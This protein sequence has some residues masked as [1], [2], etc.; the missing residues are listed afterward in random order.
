M[1]ILSSRKITQRTIWMR[2][3]VIAGLL[4]VLVGMALGYRPAVNRYMIWKQQRALAQA[5]EFIEQSDFPSAKL[6]LN[7]ALTAVPG[8]SQALRVAADLLEQAGSPEVMMLRRRLVQLEPDSLSDRVSLINSALRYRD[9]NAAKD[10]MRDFP[11]DQTDEPEAIKAALAYAM[12]TDNRPIADALYNRLK[13]IEPDNENL[14]VMHALLRLKSPRAGTVATARQELEAYASNPRFSLFI[15]REMIPAAMQRNDRD[16]ARRLAKLIAADPRAT[17]SDRLHEANFALNV[18]HRPFDEIFATLAPFAVMQARDAAELVR[19]TIIVGQ[20]AQGKSWLQTLPDAIRDSSEILPVK[21]EL[22]AVM[23]DWD[24][25]AGLLEEGAW[26]QVDR[27]TIRLAF[28][29]R[30][31]ADRKNPAL[32]RQIWDEALSAAGRSLSNLTVL[33]RVAGVWNWEVEGERSLWAITRAYPLQA[34]AHQTLFNVYRQRR[35]TENMRALIGTLREG[36]GSMLRYRHD[37][38]LLSML[39]SRS[40]VWNPAKQAMHDLYRAD[41]ANAYYATGYAF[42][43][44]QSDKADEALVVLGKLSS[45][46]LLLP[47][48]APYLAFVYGMARQQA[49]FAKAA[50]AEPDLTDL[51]PEERALFVLGRDALSRPASKRIESAAEKAAIEAAEKTGQAEA[52]P[53]AG[54]S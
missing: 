44:A 24:G 51:L 13:G 43:L 3:A 29:A 10:A 53:A 30:L 28:S 19:W 46:E 26:G 23:Q 49:D 8:D 35:D 40:P 15:R 41:P 12:A 34:W 18:D 54:S 9:I 16:E 36:D 6:A 37:W 47:A 50:G 7:V 48:R 22:A 5:K 21:A 2:R 45:N 42:A 31:A 1:Q 25:L 33:Y 4:L 38:A 32:Q 20:P 11:L 14:A 27:D 39:T 17:L 52:T